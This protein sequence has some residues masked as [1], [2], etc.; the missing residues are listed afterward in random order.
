MVLHTDFDSYLNEYRDE[1]STYSTEEVISYIT[2]ITQDSLSDVPDYF[3]ELMRK[4][5]KRYAIRSIN[6]EEILKNDPGAKEYVDSG[7]D[8]YSEEDDYPSSND[9]DLPIVIFEG[10][11]IDGY[12]RLGV[13]FRNGE[14]SIRAYVPI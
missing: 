14:K 11:V 12:N 10:E 7:E 6:I 4:A 8:R 3:F 1:E 5:N 9:L 2:D 13:H